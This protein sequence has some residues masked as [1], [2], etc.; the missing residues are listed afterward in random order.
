[1]INYIIILSKIESENPGIHN[2]KIILRAKNHFE[3]DQGN[4]GA[5]TLKG[6]PK[7]DKKDIENYGE[8]AVEV[9]FNQSFVSVENM[10]DDPFPIKK[11]MER[12]CEIV[13]CSVDLLLYTKEVD[14]NI[15]L[16]T[17]I[18]IL[19]LFFWFIEAINCN[20]IINCMF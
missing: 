17:R 10:I 5:K 4:Q 3:I 20:N 19:Y 16:L 7:Y 12:F 15:F 18:S 2:P 11:S 6:Y 13:G 1:M 9:K 14:V 8:K